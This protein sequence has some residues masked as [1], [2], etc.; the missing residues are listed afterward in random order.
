MHEHGTK[1]SS[2]FPPANEEASWLLLPSLV[3]LLSSSS[4]QPENTHIPVSSR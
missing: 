2:V 4:E 1:T 3:S